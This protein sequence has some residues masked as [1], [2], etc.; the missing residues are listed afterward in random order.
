[1]RKKETKRG[2]KIKLGG[3]RPMCREDINDGGKLGGHVQ[4]GDKWEG[5]LKEVTDMGGKLEEVT[6]NAITRI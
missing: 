2:A 3:T 4:K 1:M 5:K 6:G